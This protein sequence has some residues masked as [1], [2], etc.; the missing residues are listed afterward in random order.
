MDIYNLE[1][2][3]ITLSDYINPYTNTRRWLRGNLHGHT[4]CG[5]F[6]DAAVSGQIY[7]N[8]GYDFMAITDHNLVRLKSME[9]MAGAG[10]LGH[11]S[12]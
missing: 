1:R 5:K 8:L 3:F 9:I 2:E 12:R 4:C 7:A 11:Y 6:M 10:W